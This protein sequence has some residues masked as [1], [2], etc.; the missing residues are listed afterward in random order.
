MQIL[1]LQSYT[2]RWISCARLRASVMRAVIC[3]IVLS[4]GSCRG[5][6][7]IDRRSSTTTDSVI[8]RERTEIIPVSIPA[9]KAGIRLDLADISKLTQGA[10]FTRKEGQAAVSLSRQGDT[11]YVSATCDS[12][13]MLVESKSIEISRL[14]TRLE[15]QQQIVE[16]P[17]GWWET[18]K[19]NTFYVI[20]GMVL[21][22]II[23]L[24]RK[25][26]QR[27]TIRL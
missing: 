20:A 2:R 19:N 17:P 23:N 11:V 12:L 15:Q 6:R 14:S 26:W 21:M 7:E 5:I 18:L 25:I 3:L 24:I 9:S 27:K 4:T 10:V 16:K 1:G 22:L 8:V 13:Q